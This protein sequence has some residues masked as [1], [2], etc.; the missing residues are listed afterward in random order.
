MKKLAK[1]WKSFARL[2]CLVACIA[3]AVMFSFGVVLVIGISRQ[4]IDLQK[5]TDLAC[6]LI[7]II[8]LCWGSLLCMY[9]GEKLLKT[10]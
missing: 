9:G 5:P 6:V 8:A 1:L 10:D 3:G 7:T 2:V 4:P